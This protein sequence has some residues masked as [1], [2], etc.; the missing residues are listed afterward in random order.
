MTRKFATLMGLVTVPIVV[1]AAAS[2]STK[3][4]PRLDPTALLNTEYQLP[5]PPGGKVRVRD[6]K[7]AIEDAEG[8]QSLTVVDLNLGGDLNGDDVPDA[9][10]LLVYWGGGPAGA[11]S[12]Q[13]P[14]G[15]SRRQRSSLLSNRISN[16]S[17]HLGEERTCRGHRCVTT[18]LSSP[19]ASGGR[20]KQWPRDCRSGSPLRN[21]P[22]P[23][24]ERRPM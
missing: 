7:W 22:L 1:L 24:V 2:S 3:S 16:A 9:V 19:K 23:V 11:W 20:G 17:L 15:R 14:L 6:G 21:L 5:S 13:G 10:V 18:G 4:V 12:H 8:R